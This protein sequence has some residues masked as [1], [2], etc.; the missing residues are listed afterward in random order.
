MWYAESGRALGPGF[1][2]IRPRELF[3]TALDPMISLA[4]AVILFEGGLTLELRELGE[5]HLEGTVWLEI[6]L[7]LSGGHST[8]ELN[9]WV[10]HGKLIKVFN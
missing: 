2:V 4:V 9:L 3:G 6:L 7:H 5:R 8:M 10:L 1:D